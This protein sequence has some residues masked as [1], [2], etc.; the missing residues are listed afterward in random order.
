MLARFNHHLVRAERAHLVVYAFRHSPRVVFHAVQ[1]VWVRDHPHLP[2]SFRRP[3]QDGF[4]F[5]RNSGIERTW[6]LALFR[7]LALSAYNPALC[8]WI[9]PDL[10]GFLSSVAC[11][12]RALFQTVPVPDRA[13]A[14]VI[15]H[16]KILRQFQRIRRTGILAQAAEHAPRRIICKRRQH[17]PPRCVIAFP[18]Y[19]DQVLRA[20]Q[21]A[22]IASDAQRLPRLRVLVQPRRSSISFRYHRPFQWILLG[23]NILRKLRPERDGH[24]P[25]KVCLE[26]TFHKIFHAFSLFPPPSLVKDS[27]HSLATL[28]HLNSFLRPQ[29]RGIEGHHPNWPVP[30]WPQVIPHP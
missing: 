8:Y 21:R 2:R 1:R 3:R 7:A 11:R 17:F 30:I 16:F 28:H 10:H 27:R 20:C 25:Q 13:F 23:T 19:D 9:S 14:A 18:S 5:V 22:Q 6:C 15:S 24:A 4:S 26:Y 29:E 12:R